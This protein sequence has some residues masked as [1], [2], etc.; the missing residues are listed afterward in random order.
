MREYAGDI[1]PSKAW[2]ILA[3][4]QRAALIDVRTVPE[5]NFVGVPDLSGLN[6]N[7]ALISWQNY[8]DMARNDDFER[9]VEALGVAKDAP[10]LFL[11]RSGARSRSAAIAMTARG[12]KTC[13]NVAEG[14]EGDV[15]DANHRGGNYGWK[16]AGLHWVQR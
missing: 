6:K 10:L 8:P 5:W 11:C 1:P 13:Y 14:F 15:N 12:Y 4:D 2:E 7:V 3:K 9:T 16:V